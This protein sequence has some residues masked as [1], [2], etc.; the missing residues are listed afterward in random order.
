MMNGDND[1]I[2]Y[3]VNTEKEEKE[4]PKYR[5]GESLAKAAQILG[6]CAMVTAIMM[7]VFLPLALG[8]GALVLAFL[9]R[10]DKNFSHE[11]KSGLTWGTTAI[12]TNL[13]MVLACVYM[14]I[15]DPQ[16]HAQMNITCEQMYGQT[17]DNMWEDAKDGKL[18]L[19][20]TLPTP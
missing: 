12:V 19:E 18:D 15:F 17:F 14:L 16:L 8:A 6:I 1:L 7:T 3:V 10:S 13:V 20:Y 4:P 9:S 11:A 2:S 5:S